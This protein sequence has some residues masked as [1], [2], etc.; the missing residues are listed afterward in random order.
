MLKNFSESGDNILELS[1]HGGLGVFVL[2]VL[3]ISLRIRHGGPADRA[4][5]LKPSCCSLGIIVLV[6]SCLLLQLGCFFCCLCLRLLSLQSTSHFVLKLVL[7][8]MKMS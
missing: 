5:K 2:K 8:I 1:R 4:E 3:F 6:V 7:R